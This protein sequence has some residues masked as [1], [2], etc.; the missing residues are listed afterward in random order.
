MSI[1]IDKSVFTPEELE[2]Y[3]ALIA[4]ATVDPEASQEEMD[5]E[6]PEMPPRKKRVFEEGFEEKEVD[7]TE[8]S[9]NTRKSADP[10]L[11]AALERMEKLE[12][13]I[14][15]QEFTGI[16]K[17]YAVL[18]EDEDELANTLY[19]MKKSNEANYNAYI[20]VLDKSLD[21]VEK[22][23]IFTE[24]GKSGAAYGSTGRG[25]LGKVE[26]IADEIMKSDTNISRESA[27]AKAWEDHPELVAEYDRE[28]RK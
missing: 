25:T 10:Q 17:K 26:A 11:T 4:K 15:M 14:A 13:S 9:C 27:I 3:K 16:A 24:I 21:L 12:K 28:Y 2:T 23:G 7:E 5:E 6:R 8:K 20:A 22:S 19:E 18:G 1:K